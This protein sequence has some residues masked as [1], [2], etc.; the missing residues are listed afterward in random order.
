MD[1]SHIVYNNII[2]DRKL[3]ECQIRFMEEIK[4]PVFS[5]HSNFEFVFYFYSFILVNVY[6]LRMIQ[7]P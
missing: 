2:V 1:L 6:W 4:F 7:G 5:S 3:S